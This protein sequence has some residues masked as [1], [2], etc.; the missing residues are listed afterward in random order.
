MALMVDQPAVTVR[1]SSRRTEESL[2]IHGHSQSRPSKMDYITAV[3]LPVP[4]VEQVATGSLDGEADYNEILEEAKQSLGHGATEGAFP[5]EWDAQLLED[6]GWTASGERL[7][8]FCPRF[9]GP[10]LGDPDELDRA[11]RYILLEMDG[12]AMHHKYV[13]VYCCLGMDWSD[14]RLAHRLRVAYDILPEEYAKNLQR[15]YILHP[16]SGLRVSMWTLWSWMSKTV[17]DKIHYVADIDMLLSNLCPGDKPAQ[18]QLWRRFPQIVQ[19]NDAVI[20]GKEV[21]VTFGVSLCTICKSFGVD[22]TDKTTGRWYPMLP[23]ALIFLFEAME[24]EAG[25]EDIAKIFDADAAT[26]YSVVQTIDEG[27]PLER[28]VPMSV[29]WCVVK[30][31]LDCLPEPLLS[32]AMVEELKTRTI[33][34]ADV[35]AHRDILA[36]AFHQQLPRESAYV[37]L[38]TA[39][40]LHTLCHN[41][42]E[43]LATSADKAGRELLTPALAAKVF[44]PSFLRPMQ[45][46]QEDR[47]WVRV[48]R[49]VVETL[50][51]E[52]ELPEFWIGSQGVLQKEASDSSGGEAEAPGD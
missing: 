8:L 51:R 34:E 36:E 31:F 27:R 3:T 29:L 13:F 44:G 30:L 50:I 43:K 52:A 4:E 7:I 23:P 32:F 15:L 26:V 17:W 46:T 39:S 37:A 1:R 33:G 40:C 47:Q 19:R 5:E 16:S 12:I 24:R 14:P 2:L 6:C 28:N 9:L 25:D 38:Y 42:R 18:A 10:V 35:Q 21:P 48:G 41:S 22:F 49:A 45:M 20:T 11:F